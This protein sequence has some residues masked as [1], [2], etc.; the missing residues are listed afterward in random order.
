MRE[1]EKNITLRF[2]LRL[3]RSDRALF[4]G[5]L[6]EPFDTIADDSIATERR[7]FNDLQRMISHEIGA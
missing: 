2:Q 3:P 4:I 1:K 6:N 7:P 5:R